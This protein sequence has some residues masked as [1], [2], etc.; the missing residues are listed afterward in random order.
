MQFPIVL[1]PLCA[2]SREK[3]NLMLEMYHIH[4]HA[5]SHCSGTH[6][7]GDSLV[8]ILAAFGVLQTGLE[9][10]R[11]C[12]PSRN[13]DVVPTY[14]LPHLHESLCHFLA[15]TCSAPCCLAGDPAMPYAR[16]TRTPTAPYYFCIPFSPEHPAFRACLC[17]FR[18]VLSNNYVRG[19]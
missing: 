15:L 8:S 11:W 19:H 7:L 9:S 12:L 10:T 4:L 13:H 16:T 5:S 17:P 6:A 14:L 18:I 1:Y 2:N 3:S